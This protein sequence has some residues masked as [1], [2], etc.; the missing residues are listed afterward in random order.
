L[1]QSLTTQVYVQNPETIVEA[2]DEIQRPAGKLLT[3]IRNFDFDQMD[4]KTLGNMGIED[5]FTC[6]YS[7]IVETVQTQKEAKRFPGE[8][9]G[10]EED[11]PVPV[12]QQYIAKRIIPKDIPN[13]CE[14]SRWEIT[15]LLSTV[16]VFGGF[17]RIVAV[18]T[19]SLL[20]HHALVNLSASRLKP[21]NKRYPILVP[22]I[23]F[24]LCLSLLLFRRLYKQWF[25]S[26]SVPF[27]PTPGRRKGIARSR[28]G[29][30]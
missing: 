17:S 9:E 10:K 24:V 1:I 12:E 16:L 21:E 29:P 27:A 7:A 18:G 23:G 14:S 19:F 2:Y 3:N 6:G 15:G 11:V 25:N 26:K 28:W 30:R 4:L 22:A 8:K 13:R 5:A 20:F